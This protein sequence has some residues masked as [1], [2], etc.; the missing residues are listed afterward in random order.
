[1]KFFILSIFVLVG[2]DGVKPDL[3]LV[4]QNNVE[5]TL[6]KP[7][8]KATKPSLNSSKPVKKP[9]NKSNVQP[10]NEEGLFLSVDASVELI[11]LNQ[12]EKVITYKTDVKPVVDKH[13]IRCHGSAGEMSLREFN[14]T[15][16][17]DNSDEIQVDI[18]NEMIARMESIGDP[19]PPVSK[20][21]ESMTQGEID[22][23]KK[24]LD[25]GLKLES[26]STDKELTIK[27]DA[28]DAGG[29]ILGSDEQ[30]LKNDDIANVNFKING[31]ESILVKVFQS[32]TEIAA[33]TIEVIGT[34]A[35]GVIEVNLI[36]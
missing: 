36:K 10:T 7:I 13:C 29:K 26:K 34:Q 1:M 9:A 22:V 11:V 25:D 15:W 27:F 18:V 35:K 14:F 30:V 12:G 8:E 2:C 33:K 5:E 31:I 6:N 32:K 3:S 24:W 17:E 20:R 28:L 23:I 4:Q 16:Y 19:M 21:R